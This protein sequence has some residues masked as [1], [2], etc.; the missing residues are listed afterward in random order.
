LSSLLTEDKKEIGMG[1]DSF[2]NIFVQQ[3]ENPNT[4]D[5]NELKYFEYRKLNLQRTNRLE[6]T[7][8]PSEELINEINK[9][10][11]PQTWMVI[12]ESWCGDSAQILPIIAKAALLNHKINLRIVLRDENL[13]IM[14]RYLTN[15]SRSIPKL[16]A[17]DENDNELFQLGPRPAYAQNLM[18]KMKSDEIPKNE[19]N[20]ELHLWYAKDRGKEVERELIEL[21]KNFVQQ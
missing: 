17:F 3:V 21:L 11:R 7:F 12:T 2:R 13:D 19:I 20:K 14:D 10:D 1:Y 15:G 5:E 6:K 8:I 4:L 9:L 18:S 16:V